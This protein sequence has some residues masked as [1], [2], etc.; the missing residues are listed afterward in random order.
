MSSYLNLFFSKDYYSNLKMY[1]CMQ[2]I[3]IEQ[4]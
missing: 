1:K 4:K 3:I 2:K